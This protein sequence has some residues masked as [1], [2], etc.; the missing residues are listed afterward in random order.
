MNSSL[1]R[2]IGPLAVLPLITGLGAVGRSVVAVAMVSTAG[3]WPAH[4]TGGWPRRCGP[5]CL[6]CSLESPTDQRRPANRSS[7]QLESGAGDPT[8]PAASTNHS[9]AHH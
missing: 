6:G 8:L 7:S 3:A 9:V 2:I 5:P 4:S 1:A